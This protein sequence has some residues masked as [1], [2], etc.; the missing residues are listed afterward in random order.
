MRP[1]AKITAKK[2]IT[3]GFCFAFYIPLVLLNLL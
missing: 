1:K 3:K 2:Y